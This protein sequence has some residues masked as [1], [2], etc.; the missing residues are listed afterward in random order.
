MKIM[1]KFMCTNQKS[2]LT[3]DISVL[4]GHPYLGRTKI[5]YLVEIYNNLKKFWF[6][7]PNW[8]ITVSHQM[9]N[10]LKHF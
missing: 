7:L 4:K 8:F 3:P 1:K 5:S 10:T 2:I 6:V 9:H